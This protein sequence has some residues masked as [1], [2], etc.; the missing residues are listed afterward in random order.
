MKQCVEVIKDSFTDYAGRVH[1]FVI[2]AVVEIQHVVVRFDAVPKEIDPV[3]QEHSQIRQLKTAVRDNA[4]HVGIFCTVRSP[5]AF[6]LLRHEIIHQIGRIRHAEKQ[7]ICD[8]GVFSVGD[9]HGGFLRSPANQIAGVVYEIG[10]NCGKRFQSAFR[11]CPV[12]GSFNGR[13]NVHH[14]EIDIRVDHSEYSPIK[15]E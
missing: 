4:F 2:A 3:H 11:S 10:S 15:V 12:S 7:Q 1:H 14:I 9:D 6:C 8:V 13:I 5:C